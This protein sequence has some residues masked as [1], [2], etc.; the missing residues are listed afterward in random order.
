[1]QRLALQL[2]RDNMQGDLTARPAATGWL[3]QTTSDL[4]T[5]GT[6]T[7]CAS[8][9]TASSYMASDLTAREGSA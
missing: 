6:Y 4:P 9:V 8:D 2:T 5:G 3:H 1:M 7:T